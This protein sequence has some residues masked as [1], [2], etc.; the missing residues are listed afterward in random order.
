RPRNLIDPD[1]TRRV[2]H[3][4]FR[5]IGPRWADDKPLWAAAVTLLAHGGPGFRDAR[6]GFLG[7]NRPDPSAPAFPAC[8]L[9][10]CRVDPVTLR[11][12]NFAAVTSGSGSADT[13]FLIQVD[14][15]AWKAVVGAPHQRRRF[16]SATCLAGQFPLAGFFPTLPSALNAALR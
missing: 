9:V 13:T 12:G 3:V 8:L 10:P 5:G 14:L 2:S 15:G 11:F 4:K 1:A 16:D 7:G 6:S